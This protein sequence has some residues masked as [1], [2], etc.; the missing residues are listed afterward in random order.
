MLA[1]VFKA[2]LW[3]TLIGLL[4]GVVAGGLSAA[5]FGLPFSGA[6]GLRVF[7][8]GMIFPGIIFGPVAAAIG[9]VLG[10]GFVWCRKFWNERG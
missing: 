1:C 5:L 9:A 7:H 8:R 6:K 4:L 10:A 3:G 2:A